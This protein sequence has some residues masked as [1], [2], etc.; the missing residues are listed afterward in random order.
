[1]ANVALLTRPT[2]SRSSSLADQPEVVKS[3]RRKPEVEIAEDECDGVGLFPVGA[4]L[5]DD[6][7]YFR[8]ASETSCPFSAAGS[9][10]GLTGS[11]CRASSKH[12]RSSSGVDSISADELASLVAAGNGSDVTTVVVVDCRCFVAFNANHVTGAFN[13]TC[14]D[15][16]SRKR[17]TQGRA[18]VADLVSG[19]PP[20]DEP[21]QLAIKAKW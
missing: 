5:A 19:G 12:F 16:F 14:S 20:T 6:A 3:C 10:N 7:G 4:P 17:L 21:G 18:T 11:G 1:M 9:G 13:A 2:F 8:V 15:K